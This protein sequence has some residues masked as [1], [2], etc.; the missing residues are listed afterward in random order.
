MEGVKFISTDSN[1]RYKKAI[2]ECYIYSRNI[3]CV[4]MQMYFYCSRM[5]LNT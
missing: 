5:Q 1:N 4:N 2:R 3:S